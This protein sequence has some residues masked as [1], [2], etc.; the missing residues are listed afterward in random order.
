MG[1]GAGLAW[2]NS[3]GKPEATPVDR[4]GGATVNI[5]VPRINSTDELECALAVDVEAS[6]GCASFSS[7]AST[8]S[9]SPRTQR[10]S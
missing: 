4:A 2:A 1:V 3:P 7:G 8:R 5:Q 9:R 10:C 6:Y